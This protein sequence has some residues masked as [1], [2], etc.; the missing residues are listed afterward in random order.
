[1][2]DQNMYIHLLAGGLAGSTGTII[3]CPLE[4][5]KTRQQS[6][7][8]S[9]LKFSEPNLQVISNSKAAGSIKHN[10]PITSNSCTSNLNNLNN[11]IQYRFSTAHNF[12]L[13]STILFKNN[14]M[15]QPMM[16]NNFVNS[17]NTASKSIQ[18]RAGLRVYLHLKFILANE[19]YR[20]LFKGL[21][22]T[23]IGVV[24]NRAIYFYSYANSKKFLSKHIS[25]DSPLLHVCSAFLAG[26]SAVTV[27]NPIWFVKTRMQLDETRRGVSVMEVAT[28]IFREKGLIGFY[29]G[30]SA[31]YFGIIE[32]AIYFSIYEQLKSLTNQEFNDS[33][34]FSK[35]FSYFGSAGFSKSLASCLCYPHEVARTRLR[36]EGNKYIGFF[37][38]LQTVVKEEGPRGLYRGMGTHLMR[39]IPNSMIVMITYELI[40]NCMI[41]TES[42]KD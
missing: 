17:I 28:K 40:V 35:F 11:R 36:E 3:T 2:S 16:T 21:G 31:S 38:T 41:A 34:S 42:E 9:L 7:T 33:Q 8:S 19:G 23:L 6:S 13:N 24:P 39:Q 10:T 26:F 22:P 30:I 18:P 4:V 20:A 12:S 25:K 15:S 1:M 27:T 29:K 5:I 32:T 14:H 37:Q